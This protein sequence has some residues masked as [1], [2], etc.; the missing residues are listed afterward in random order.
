MERHNLTM[1]YII[2]AVDRPVVYSCKHCYFERISP[3]YISCLPEFLEYPATN[4][5]TE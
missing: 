4:I 5:S 3:Y 1:R 2:K